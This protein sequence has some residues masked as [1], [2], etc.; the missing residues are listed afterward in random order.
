MKRFGLVLFL[1]EF[2]VTGQAVLPS[3]AGGGQAKIIGLDANGKTVEVHVGQRLELRLEGDKPTTGWEIGSGDVK[4]IQGQKVLK[5]LGETFEPRKEAKDRAI[6][7]YIFRYEAVA[8]GEVHLVARY[9]FPGGPDVKARKATK[10]VKEMKVTIK[11]T[12]RG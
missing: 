5:G 7:T 3:L 8:E 12:A 2:L 1:G 10:L 6:G 9:V 4:V 11:V